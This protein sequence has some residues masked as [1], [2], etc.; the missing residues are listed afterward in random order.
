MEE[1][2]LALGKQDNAYFLPIVINYFAEHNNL[3]AC[4]QLFDYNLCDQIQALAL[5]PLGRQFISQPLSFAAFLIWLVQRGVAVDDILSTYILQDYALYPLLNED[6]AYDPRHLLY[7]ILNAREDTHKLAK[8]MSVTACPQEE[9]AHF[10]LNGDVSTNKRLNVVPRVAV[11]ADITPDSKNLLALERLFG[12]NLIIYAIHNQAP[13]ITLRSMLERNLSVVLERLEENSKTVFDLISTYTMLLQFALTN[14]LA[15]A[16]HVFNALIKIM[17]DA[18]LVYP[19]LLDDGLLV[20]DLRRCKNADHMLTEHVQLL[21]NELHTICRQEP[22]DWIN[23]EDSWKKSLSKIAILQEI[24]PKLQTFLPDNIYKLYA[25]VARIKFAQQGVWFNL[26]DFI[27]SLNVVPEYDLLEIKIYERLLLELLFTLDSPFL[28]E[29]LIAELERVIRP[30]RSFLQ[31][32]YNGCTLMKKAAENDNLGMLRYLQKN[33]YKYTTNELRESVL[34]AAQHGSW[35]VVLYLHCKFNLSQDVVNE[36]LIQV[37]LQRSAIIIPRLFV[38]GKNFPELSVLEKMFL[39]AAEQSDVASINALLKCPTQPCITVIIKAFSRELESEVKCI[40][41][42]TTIANYKTDNRLF[43]EAICTA[44]IKYS[45]KRD[46]LQ[47]LA[48]LK[49]HPLIDQHTVDA[50]FITAV[51][52]GQSE[53]VTCIATFGIIKPSNTAI[54]KAYRRP[55]KTCFSKKKSVESTKQHELVGL[56]IQDNA[57]TNLARLS[58]FEKLVREEEKV[59]DKSFLS[60]PKLMRHN[61]S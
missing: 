29:E 4:S 20:R 40:D 2:K 11:R 46:V 7:Q 52:A 43:K 58:Y 34:L 55:G 54:I 48:L 56:S 19:T 41:I 60:L 45:G 14:N 25:Y 59:N 28:R 17:L 50:A 35:Q 15:L 8:K 13:L 44:L 23:V 30:P 9:L 49:N 21:E 33:L 61:S 38:D 24:S 1:C 5:A 42:V 10:A 27:E 39:K 22:F 51:R 12:V 36:I 31:T 16:R 3:E 32:N 18:V 6:D 26:R 47:I 57:V 53:N 37:V